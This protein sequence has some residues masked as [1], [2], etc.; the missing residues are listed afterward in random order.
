MCLSCLVPWP[1]MGRIS[2]EA[3]GGENAQSPPPYS[4]LW[5]WLNLLLVRGQPGRQK[6]SSGR[7]DDNRC[8]VPLWGWRLCENHLP[9]ILSDVSLSGASRHHHHTQRT[10]DNMT[11]SRPGCPDSRQA[12]GAGGLCSGNERMLPRNGPLRSRWHAEIFQE[13]RRP[14][15][16]HQGDERERNHVY[17]AL[18]MSRLWHR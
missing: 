16:T 18:T 6:A 1:V 17:W 8:R 2:E 11:C 12:F 13:G 10:S 9:G 3:P 15:G 4:R 5:G 7:H 14:Q